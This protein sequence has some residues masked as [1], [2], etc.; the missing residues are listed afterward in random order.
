MLLF[1]IY[2]YFLKRNNATKTYVL[3]AKMNTI[4]ILTNEEKEI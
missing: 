4:Q 1:F 2:T 3:S